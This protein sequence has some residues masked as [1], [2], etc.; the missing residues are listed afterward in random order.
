MD[1]GYGYQWWLS[2]FDINIDAFIAKGFGGQYILAFP[3]KDL[4]VVITGGNYEANSS[5][6]PNPFII[7]DYLVYDHILTALQ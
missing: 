6:D 5:Q 3:E 2:E 4:V 7:F 1:K